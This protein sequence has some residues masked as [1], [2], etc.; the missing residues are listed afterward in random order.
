MQRFHQ[1]L[2]A[3]DHE[4]AL[5][6]VDA[7]LADFPTQVPLYLHRARTLHALGR[8]PEARAAMDRV[9]ELRGEHGPTLLYR[10]ELRALLG[11]DPEQD[12]RR[13]IK[14]DP[15]LAGAHLLLARTLASR[16]PEDAAAAL[17]RALE[18]DPHL[19]AAYAE[20][21][22]W[23]RV[24]AAALGAAAPDS[25]ELVI[26]PRGPRYLRARLA[27]A[28][29][30]Y[31][32]A[33]AER[34]DADVR[35]RLAEVLYEL[36]D[37]DAALIACDAAL[38][39]TPVGDPQYAELL[40][41]HAWAEQRG[42]ALPAEVAARVEQALV[43]QP[44]SPA[45]AV[46]AS[47]P[48]PV[49]PALPLLS[50]SE[51]QAR[52]PTASAVQAR[53]LQVAHRLYA[54]AALPEPQ[55]TATR[56]ELY[57]RSMREYAER[58]AQALDAHGF[59]VV[60]DYEP[61]H[62]AELPAPTLTRFLASGDGITAAVAWCVE[63]ARRGW[64][65]NWWRRVRGRDRRVEVL[66]LLTLFDDGGLLLTTNRGAD[67][68]AYGG[69]IDGQ[70]LAADMTPAAAYDQHRQR[71]ER[72]RQQHPSAIA[73]RVDT[74]ARQLQLQARLRAAR[75]AYRH[76]IGYVSDDELAALLGPEREL[77]GPRVRAALADL[78]RGAG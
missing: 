1:A 46:P 21:A 3:G 9:V 51:T 5:G 53:A 58:V 20:R 37:Y 66:E 16:R 36:A 74:E 25:S 57:P 17:E 55:Y 39:L 69:D 4:A 19:A 52:W 41:L 18:I 13:A 48:V 10:A 6:I 12:L 45:A 65:A 59:R 31:L 78:V 38:A 67:L 7:L 42:Q 28:K 14:E 15:L 61:A 63:P 70:A 27:Q 32:R 22:D 23:H 30:D 73:E 11:E 56:A 29:T 26:S 72:Y 50:W 2:A 62:L 47:A 43:A 77:L 75:C 64:L 8:L 40:R 49:A 68:W 33:L 44:A 76:A 34:N 24:A 71:I 54:L 60:G 35:R